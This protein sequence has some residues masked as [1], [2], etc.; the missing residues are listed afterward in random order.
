M[1]YAVR[2][3]CRPA[4][5]GRDSA[6][7]VHC[8]WRRVSDAGPLADGRADSGAGV[9]NP[10]PSE[11]S[12]NALA[13]HSLGLVRG[14]YSCTA[15]SI[16]ATA[17]ASPSSP[18]TA[19]PIVRARSRIASSESAVLIAA[20]SASAVG[21]QCGSGAGAKPRALSRR[22]HANWSAMK[23]VTTEGFPALIAAPVV[24]ARHGGRLRPCAETAA[25]SRAKTNAPMGKTVRMK[26]S[27]SH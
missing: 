25:S 2:R 16:A 24:P 14:G 10:S 5:P 8:K 7:F 1:S 26:T 11:T 27:P 9:R 22:A 4:K 15:R 20:A 3:L 17:R 19:E 21:M 23:G 13:V 6:N 12:I 18:R